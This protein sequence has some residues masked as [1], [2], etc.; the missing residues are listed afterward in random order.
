MLKKRISIILFILLFANIFAQDAREK[1]HSMKTLPFIEDGVQKYYITWS[2]SS[3]SDDGWQHDIYN[4]IISFTS[5]GEINFETDA[6]RFIGSGNDEAQEPVN[7][8]INPNNNTILSVWEDGSGSTVDIRGQMHKSDGTIIKSNWIISGGEDS[9]HSPDVEH[10]DVV[11]IVSLTD[12]ASPAQTSMNEVRILNDETGEQIGSLELSPKE[13]DHW[14]AVSTSNN[15]SFA[16][17]G[18]GNGEDFYGSVLKADSNSVTKIERKF[19][20]SNIDQY[21]YSVAWLDKLSK[22]IVVARVNNK[23]VACL[24]DTNGVRS[25]FTSISNAP[26]TRE[27][28]L[29]VWWDEQNNDYKISYTSSVRD[30]TTI[31]ISNNE[32]TLQQINKD[33]LTEGNWPTTG[34]VCE[35][36]HS[37]DGKDLWKSDRKI[38]IAHNDEKSNNPI[39]YFQ[40]VDDLTDISQVEN[41]IINEF[42]L[43]PSYPNPFNPTTTIKY[44]IPKNVDSNFSPSTSTLKVYDV[45]GKEITTL[46][47]KIQKPGNYKVNFDGSN[48]T[49]GIY[50]YQLKSSYF[51]ETKKMILL[52]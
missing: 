12:E 48:L 51:S 38:F 7:V 20:I 6:N 39:Y 2:S 30:L 29:A 49:S 28:K 21:Y 8:A 37:K 40:S 17:V 46:V 26:I 4:Q 24:I 52:K 18:W 45:Q 10:L 33:F 15:M 35:F 9:Q 42:H 32:I 27:T 44:L 31:N 25:N 34:I 22:F 3:G 13:E 5:E 1:N 43:F 47:N 14:W 50:Y 11:F 16:F 41:K 23:S 36:V 19:Y